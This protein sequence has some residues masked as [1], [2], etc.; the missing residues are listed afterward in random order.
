MYTNIQS[1][2]ARVLSLPLASG[3][4]LCCLIYRSFHLK[5]VSEIL[6]GNIKLVP[7][8]SLTSSAE[9]SSIS[10]DNNAVQHLGIVVHKC[11]LLSI[12]GLCDSRC[13]LSQPDNLLCG[14]VRAFENL[15][16][17]IV[18][19][20]LSGCLVEPKAAAVVICHIL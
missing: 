11:A 19:A 2:D 10:L 1:G 13:S 12:T 6:E 7:S 18:R 3:S 9:Y 17:G 16:C 5:K 8:R 14:I 4:F 15:L 20:L